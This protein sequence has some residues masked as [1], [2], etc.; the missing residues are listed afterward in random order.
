M[1]EID[2]EPGDY[3]VRGGKRPAKVKFTFFEALSFSIGST[4]ATRKKAPP[5]PAKSARLIQGAT[6]GVI[7]Y[8][9]HNLW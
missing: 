9:T 1:P 7:W 6:L 8:I 3:R 5:D 2:L 4:L